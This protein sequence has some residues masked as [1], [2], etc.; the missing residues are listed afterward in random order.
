MTMAPARLTQMPNHF[1]ASQSA[2][3]TWM[4]YTVSGMRP[5]GA[6]Q[7]IQRRSRQHSEQTPTDVPMLPMTSPSPPVWPLASKNSGSRTY[8][9]SARFATNSTV[10]TTKPTMRRLGAIMCLW[11]SIPATISVAHITG[12]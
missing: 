11:N 9:R 2:V 7:P 6:S 10:P 1:G 12:E 5:S 8:Q 4:Q 3:S